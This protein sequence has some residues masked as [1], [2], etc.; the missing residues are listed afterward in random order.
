V[1]AYSVVAH[2]SLERTSPGLQ[3]F[4]RVLARTDARNDGQVLSADA[5][6]PG[7]TLLAEADSDHWTFLLPLRGHP[8][9]LVR[10]LAADLPYP[11][12]EFFRALLR[13]VLE[14]D[15]NPVTGQ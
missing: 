2:T 3:G 1:R 5:I 4:Y 7:S 11:R 9:L 14:L 8:R 12:Q 13:T 10:S 15:A 6:L